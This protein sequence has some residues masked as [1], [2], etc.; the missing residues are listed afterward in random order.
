M[1]FL[2]NII[3]DVSSPATLH[4]AGPA[5]PIAVITLWF[6]ALAVVD[7][8]RAVGRLGRSRG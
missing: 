3:G 5:V 2:G 1:Q 8:Y 6:A 7:W 4:F